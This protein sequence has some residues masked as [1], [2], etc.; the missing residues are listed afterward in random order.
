M[1]PVAAPTHEQH[2]LL[3][4][5]E[6]KGLEQHYR[7]LLDLPF[8][9][10]FDTAPGQKL[11]TGVGAGHAP[12]GSLADFERESTDTATEGKLL[13]R[14]LFRR[15]YV[16]HLRLRGSP[17]AIKAAEVHLLVQMPACVQYEP[18]GEKL[19]AVRHEPA[20]VPGD[21]APALDVDF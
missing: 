14:L 21:P 12:L 8:L 20:P 7:A 10:F 16:T 11:E 15:H 13:L 2:Y 1:D 18:G 3:T 17:E 9:P 4:S 6:R 19:E 5:G